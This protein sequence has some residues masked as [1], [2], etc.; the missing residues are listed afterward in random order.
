MAE[1]TKVRNKSSFH[2]CTHVAQKVIELQ[3]N[4]LFYRKYQLFWMRYEQFKI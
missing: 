4:R 3:S 1:N 2:S